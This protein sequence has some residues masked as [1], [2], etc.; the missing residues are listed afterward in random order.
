MKNRYVVAA[1]MLSILLTGCGDEA[2]SKVDHDRAIDHLSMQINVLHQQVKE[3]TKETT[4]HDVHI[5]SL[6]AILENEWPGMVQV[7]EDLR[8][9]LD[10][11]IALVDMADEI[12]GV[13][14]AFVEIEDRLMLL[15]VGGRA[16]VGVGD[17]DDS[18]GFESHVATPARAM[19]ILRI[20]T[21]PPNRSAD[22]EIAQLRQRAEERLVEA[23]KLDREISKLHE[24]YRGWD[25]YYRRPEYRDHY[26]DRMQENRNQR[27]EL[28]RQRRNLENEARRL[29]GQATRL[30]NEANTP[31]QRIVG[32]SIDGDIDFVLQ[33]ERDFSAQLSRIADGSLITWRG[34]LVGQDGFSQTWVV[35]SISGVE[36]EEGS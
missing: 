22:Q 35:S 31:K 3:L 13:L 12:E 21:L 30:E 26:R 5:E 11:L 27:R 28:A 9:E 6:T 19:R 20:E 32:E 2:V 10:P 29:N 25:R 33:T 17:K 8:D 34:R 7:F 14:A 4:R 16:R 24:I 36:V 1:G 15:E 18:D 23:R